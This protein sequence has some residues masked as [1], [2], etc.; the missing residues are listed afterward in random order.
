MRGINDDEILDFAR[1][2]R[3]RGVVVRFIEFMDVGYT[4]GWQMEHVVPSRELAEHIAHA[5]L[6]RDDRFRPLLEMAELKKVHPSTVI[7]LVFTTDRKW[8]APQTG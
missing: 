6:A 3:E 8:G 7:D 5:A 1:F 2:G 4:N